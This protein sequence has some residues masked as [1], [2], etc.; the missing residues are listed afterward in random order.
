LKQNVPHPWKFYDTGAVNFGDSNFIEPEKGGTMATSR[1][2]GGADGSGRV[3]PEGLARGLGWFSIG[4][5]L[6]EVLAPRAVARIAGARRGN[7]ALVRLLGLREIAH[8]VA[9]FAQGRRPAAALWARVGGDVLDLAVLAGVFATPG[10]SKGRTAFAT[11]NV[12]GV[13]AL[14]VLGA[15]LLSE[16]AAATAGAGPVHVVTTLVINRPAEELYRFWRDFEN[17]PR[18]MHHLEQVRVTGEGRSHWVAKG[19][20]GLSVEWDAELTGEVPNERISWRSLPGADVENS[21]TISFEEAAGGRGTVVRLELTYHPPGGVVGKWAAR[22]L[23]EEP[24]SQA[25]NDLR[26]FKQLMETGEVVVSD[27]TLLGNGVTEQRP[28]Q[29]PDETALAAAAARA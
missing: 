25:R 27:A 10:T 11:A 28:G 13:A 19:P 2:G 1:N 21:G 12:L 5:G 22:L 3:T 8:G 23:G 7:T 26:R 29:P 24:E 15:Q 18:F 20:A 4:L 16:G 14:D 6:T 17:L 9:I